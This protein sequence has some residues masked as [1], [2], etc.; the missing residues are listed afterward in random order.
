MRWKICIV[1]HAGNVKYLDGC[2][3]H[4]VELGFSDEGIHVFCGKGVAVPNLPYVAKRR[5]TEKLTETQT[6]LLALEVMASTYASTDDMFLFISPDL[7]LWRKLK[8]FC[9]YTVEEEFFAIY[10]PYTPIRYY[11]D[12]NFKSIPCESKKAAWCQISI[13]DPVHS[14]NAL[15][16]NNH[17][18]RLVASYLRDALA[19]KP[20]EWG[21]ADLFHFAI[22]QLYKVT[23]YSA[24]PSF[25]RSVANS[26][27]EFVEDYDQTGINIKRSRYLN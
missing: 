24:L 10:L 27:V 3:S 15:L 26:P 20:G 1:V 8:L 2:I 4:L 14:C 9:E 5:E 19:R 6:W 25:V 7:R 12:S 17:S 22:G 16:L 18:A 13:D 11:V 23:C 21:W